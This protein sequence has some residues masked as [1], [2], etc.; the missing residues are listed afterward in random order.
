MP[1]T[2][3]DNRNISSSFM[4]CRVVL[5]AGAQDG[6]HGLLQRPYGFREKSFG[7]Q[8]PQFPLHLETMLNCLSH[9]FAS[10]TYLKNIQED[11][12]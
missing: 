9:Q 10:K 3:F 2:P 7:W 8:A 1:Q 12:Y 4:S 11:E 6:S 5:G